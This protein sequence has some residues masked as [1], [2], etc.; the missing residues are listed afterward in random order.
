MLV[1]MKKARDLVIKHMMHRCVHNQLDITDALEEIAKF[2]AE[3]TAAA[4][5]MDTFE[6]RCYELTD[7]GFS[8]ER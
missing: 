2:N 5:C 1:E 7:G 6:K 8:P 4:A 3:Y